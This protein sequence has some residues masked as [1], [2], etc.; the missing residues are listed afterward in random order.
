MRRVLAIGALGALL[1]V[2]GAQAGSRCPNERQGLRSAATA[3]RDDVSSLGRLH[4]QL[5]RLN[6]Q[7]TSI[8]LRLH[9]LS[10]AIDQHEHEIRKVEVF[11]EQRCAGKSDLKSSA[12]ACANHQGRLEWLHAAIE[13][14]G[15]EGDALAARAD[16]LAVLVARVEQSQAD[17]RAQTAKDEQSLSDA[18]SALAAC[19]G[20]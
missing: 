2:T 19:L 9:H 17:M 16:E 20:S 14:L 18:K 6:R 4:S 13:R 12:V 10:L 7:G 11:L 5:V 8:G 15:A 3:L 1:S